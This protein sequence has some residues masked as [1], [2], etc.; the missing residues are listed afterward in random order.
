M[1]IALTHNQRQSAAEEEAEFYHPA[2]VA[3]LTGALASGGHEVEA[4]E[5]SGPVGALVARLNAFRPDLVFN[6]AEGRRGRAREAF[7]PALFAEL[8]FPHTGSD[9]HVLLVGL[10][11]WLTKLALAQHGVPSPRATFLTARRGARADVLEGVTFPAIVKPN[12][13]GSS[14]GITDDSVCEDARALRAT[15]DRI[16]ATYPEGV[17]VEEFIPGVDLTVPYLEG[18]GDEGVLTPTQYEVTA[19]ER[20]RYNLYDYRLKNVTENAVS[21]RCPADV[22]PELIARLQALTKI[23]VSAFDVRDLGR[24]D[25]RLGKDGRLHFIELNALPFLDPGTSM[26]VAAGAEGLGYDEMILHIVG[27]SSRR[28]RLDARR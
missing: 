6:T 11:K 26:A 9:A 17:L 20:S 25:F 15:V 1:K 23:V 8:G 12:F 3:A 7:Y 5:V 4:I 21:V 28:W 24:V 10:D 19:S 13:E 14:K 18:L 22:S 27:S 2:T 16:L